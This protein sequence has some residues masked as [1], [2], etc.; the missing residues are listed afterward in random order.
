M[1]QNLLAQAITNNAGDGTIKNPAIGTWGTGG[2]TAAAGNIAQLIGTF[3][4]TMVIVAGLGFILYFIL[5]AV[6]W[7]TSGGD[8][9]KVEE[10][11][12]EITNAAIGLG[13]I[14]AL[15]AIAAFLKTVLQIDLLNIVWPTPS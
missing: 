3:I 5:G 11:K 15:Y 10:A 9:G 6:H 13:I 7:I 8:K 2:N 4:R 12:Q 14:L 1:S